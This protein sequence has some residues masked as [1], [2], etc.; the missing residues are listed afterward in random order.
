M[1]ALA[2]GVYIPLE[3]IRKILSNI[4]S[5]QQLINISL[6]SHLWQRLVF[7]ILWYEVC[8]KSPSQ[9]EKLVAQIEAESVDPE[10]CISAHICVL[11]VSHALHVFRPGDKDQ[12]IRFQQIIPK[13]SSL[14]H[15][16]WG[17]RSP[18]RVQTIQKFQQ[19]CPKIRSID[20][21]YTRLHHPAGPLDQSF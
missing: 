18:D 14:T 6:V 20:L 19:Y 8:P 9:I 4:E 21:R 15:L 7:P 16:T 17:G 2:P 11:H 10:L 5:R 12:L 1:A 3:L 13:M